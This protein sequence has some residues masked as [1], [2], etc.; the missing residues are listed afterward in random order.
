MPSGTGDRVPHKPLAYGTKGCVRA[1][2][3]KGCVR[4]YGTKGCVRAY[5]KNILK[6]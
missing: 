4:A 1:Y 5:G 3:T 2:G 6:K